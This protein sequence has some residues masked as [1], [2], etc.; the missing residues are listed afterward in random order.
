MAYEIE[1]DWIT[2]SGLR[3]VCVIMLNCGWKWHRC[4]YVEVPAT[5]R[6]YGVSYSD[7]LSDIPQREAEQATLGNKSLILLFTAR[8]G[9]FEGETVRRSLDVVIDCHGGLTYSGEGYPVDTKGWW[10]GFDCGHSG[11]AEI[12]PYPEQ[13]KWSRDGIVRDREYV[14]CE[15][16]RLAE[17]IIRL[18]PIAHVEESNGR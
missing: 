11:D 1:S 2:K 9:A 8:C 15:C 14:E 10:F 3:A 5:H 16:E 17:Q 4:G 13:L 12:E 6:L 18:F 7:P